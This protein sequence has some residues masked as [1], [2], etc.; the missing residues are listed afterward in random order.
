MVFR[1]YLQ[2]SVMS[3]CAQAEELLALNSHLG[4]TAQCQ[5]SALSKREKEGAA[6]LGAPVKS[7]ISQTS[8]AFN[9]I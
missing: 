7:L 2:T 1:D 3:P 9:E 8:G 6:L 4:T 5:L